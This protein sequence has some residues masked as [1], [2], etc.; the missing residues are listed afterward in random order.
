M[1]VVV[2]TP[3]FHPNRGL[4][5]GCSWK[6][7]QKLFAIPWPIDLLA[8]GPSRGIM[9]RRDTPLIP[10]IST[11]HDGALQL[12]YH[13]GVNKVS[14]LPFFFVSFPLYSLPPSLSLSLSLSLCFF[15]RCFFF[16]GKFEKVGETSDESPSSVTG[17]K[18]SMNSEAALCAPPTLA[19]G[20][21]KISVLNFYRPTLHRGLPDPSSSGLQ[22]IH[23]LPEYFLTICEFP[24]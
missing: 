21:E 23:L 12:L 4:S 22:R 2:E 11:G 16:G 1:V 13:T 6:Q 8:K 18:Y 5:T 24:F 7:K 17:I 3:L 9:Q 15:L 14:P 20:N 19:K 10:K